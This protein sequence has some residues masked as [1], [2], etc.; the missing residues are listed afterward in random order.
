MKKV[1]LKRGKEV[2]FRN[3]HLWIFSGAIDSYPQGYEEGAIYPVYSSQDE[4]LGHAYFHR[5]QSLA[6]RIVAFGDEDPWTAICRHLDQALAL[7][8]A[9]FN[10]V[11]TNGF[12]LVNGEG[13]HLPGLTIDQ[14]ADY[15]VLQSGTLGI[16]LLKGKIVQYLVEKKRWKGI[17]EKSASGSRKEEGL[18]ESIGVIWGDSQEEIL[19]RENGLHFRVNWEKGQKTGFFLDQREMRKLVQRMSSGRKVLNCFSYTGGFSIYALAGGASS[20]DSL[21][22]SESALL[23]GQENLELNGG[24]KVPTKWI[25]QDAFDFLRSDPLKY[26]LIILDPPAFIKK[27]KD[28]TQGLRGYREINYQV[29]SKIPKGSFLLTCSCSYYLDEDSFRSLL[30]QAAQKAGR[31]VQVIVES[32][33]APDHPVNLFH[34]EGRYLKSFLLYVA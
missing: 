25:S 10:P 12:R 3:R 17:F 4:L 29:L 2:I 11:D 32:F 1:V 26:D 28:L 30:F 21:D 19:I 9:L 14:Y 22:I 27:K 24:S 34:P 13:D 33:H 6:G 31:D 20:V 15:L 8:E 5:G 18:S 7:R 16:D 23:M